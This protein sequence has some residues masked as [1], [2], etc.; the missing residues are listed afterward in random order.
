MSCFANSLINGFFIIGFA[1]EDGLL[2]SH[3]AGL[4]TLWADPRAK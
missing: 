1:N 4:S 2:P 3:P